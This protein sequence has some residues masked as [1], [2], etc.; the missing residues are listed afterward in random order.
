MADD[1]GHLDDIV[2]G[3]IAKLNSK[4]DLSWLRPKLAELCGFSL[5]RETFYWAPDEDVDQ[6]VRC[7]EAFAMDTQHVELSW[8]GAAWYC[9]M[10]IPLKTGESRV[11]T[12]HGPMPRAICLAIAAALGW[13]KP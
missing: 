13:E 3:R 2:L 8:S 5:K 12:Q 1:N 11:I 7:L 9:V 6:A 10:Q 4:D